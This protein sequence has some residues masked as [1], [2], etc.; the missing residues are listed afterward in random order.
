MNE[1]VAILISG[2]VFT[3]LLGLYDRI[4]NRKFETAKQNTGIKLDD[5]QYRQIV[6][7]T[8]QT[9]VSNMTAVGAFWQGQFS[10]V[11]RQ[12]EEQRDW[13]R[14]MTVRLYEHRV[15]DQKLLARL[16]DCDINDIDPP[17]SLDPD[18]P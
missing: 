17:P 13:R 11:T 14:R 1:W 7:Q 16:H 10:E 15:W 2:G 6:A 4:R 5:A 18:E 3:I 8:E 12:L 9:S